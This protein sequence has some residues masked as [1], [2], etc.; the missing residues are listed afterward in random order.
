MEMA[1]RP[2]R[3]EA[4]VGDWRRRRCMPGAV[5]GKGSGECRRRDHGLVG[6]AIVR[7]EMSNDQRKEEA[8][9]GADV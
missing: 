9:I 8:R 2:I 1:N 7:H 6:D 4:R 3:W 5:D